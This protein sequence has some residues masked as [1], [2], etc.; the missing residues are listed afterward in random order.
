MQTTQNDTTI[1]KVENTENS[2]EN[3]S[4][5]QENKTE[6]ENMKNT[7][8]DTTINKEEDAVDVSDNETNV[9]EEEFDLSKSETLS[10][11]IENMSDEK[12]IIEPM[13]METPKTSLQETIETIEQ[14]DKHPTLSNIHKLTPKEEL[15]RESVIELTN[16]MYK[17]KISF[18]ESHIILG[19]TLVEIKKEV[20]SRFFNIID[21]EVIPK[22]QAHR[23]MKL[24]LKH[25]VDFKTAMKTSGTYLEML[26]N[27]K[28]LELDTR[29]T[30][31]VMKDLS[32]LYDISINKINKMK[33]LNDKDFEKVVT[34]DDKPYTNLLEKQK[35]EIKKISD[36]K[37]Y[38][39]K[40]Y[41][42]SKD[43]F[44][45]L[46]A[47]TKYEL[48]DY[49]LEKESKISK[50]KE[51]NEKKEKKIKELEKYIHSRDI[52]LS[53]MEGKVDVLSEMKL[54]SPLLQEKDI[55]TKSQAEVLLN[56]IAS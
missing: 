13:E 6:R 31:L 18:I 46:Y 8:N 42:I 29:V 34:G 39:K 11:A 21:E 26:E 16:T 37:H 36:E 47:K 43:K 20:K 32:N 40:P 30:D 50:L 48:I 53:M 24:V 56:S 55:M 35:Q 5:N 33:L 38:K 51:K 23:L 7:Q 41:K 15:K 1:N 45:E 3:N 4:A 9:T 49:N 25:D 54:N 12:L 44:D 14:I 52:K 2:A 28:L 10:Y 27:L 17:S 19:Y 22:K